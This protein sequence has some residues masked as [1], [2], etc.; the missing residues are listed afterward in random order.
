[1]SYFSCTQKVM[2]SSLGN[3]VLGLSLVPQLAV[4]S[5]PVLTNRYDNQRSGVNLHETTLKPN[6]IGKDTFG[7]LFS[8]N[9]DGHVYAQP[10]FVPDV[11]LVDGVKRNIVFVATM[12]NTV[13]AFDADQEN[14][15]APIWKR[16]LGFA[17]PLPD[18]NLGGS[19]TKDIYGTI[20]IMSTPV[21][22]LDKQEMYVVTLQ[23]RSITI[24]GVV[25][26][27][28][29]VYSLH[30]LDINTGASKGREVRIVGSWPTVPGVK[31]NPLDVQNGR[32]QFIPTHQL[33]RVGLL[34]HN[35]SVYVAFGSRQDIEPYHGWI[36]RYDTSSD[37]MVTVLN[38]NPDSYGGGIWQSGAGLSA[39]DDERYVYAVTGDGPSSDLAKMSIS[40]ARNFP[41][42]VLKLVDVG[43]SMLPVDAFTP[44][45]YEFLYK[46]NLDLS[47]T[48]LV[49]FPQK[50]IFRNTRAG[51]VAGKDGRI[52]I[53]NTQDLGGLSASETDPQLISKIPIKQGLTPEELTGYMVYGTPIYWETADAEGKPVGYIYVQSQNDVAKAFE[54]RGAEDKLIGK[55]PHS[56]APESDI[57]NIGR[58]GGMM[59]LSAHGTDPESGVLW[60]SVPRIRKD[61]ANHYVVEG[62]LRA[63]KATDLSQKIWDSEQNPAR[64]RLGLFAKFNTPLITNGKV[65][66]ATFS[67]E[68]AVYGKLPTPAADH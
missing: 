32:I 52:Y 2:R 49:L 64:D 37:K 65:Y 34:L 43:D 8:L 44:N 24:Q 68:V 45:Y 36:F 26:F 53:L 61:D 30:R 42:S 10:L 28:S 27:F 39:F 21:I 50:S 12:N 1:M 7:K 6:E 48:G 14:G 57:A 11:T 55:T 4:A 51:M 22:D 38:T 56:Q 59:A 54:V 33:Q 3:L 46:L 16:E 13:Y 5:S 23:R 18:R 15:G 63:Y 29:Y 17:A 47:S 35:G 67:N 62:V 9:V 31:Y 41:S 60:V 66:V 40:S 58:P 19:A 20:G 25:P